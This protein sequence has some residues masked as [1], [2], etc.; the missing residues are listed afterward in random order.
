MGARVKVEALTTVQPIPGFG[1]VATLSERPYL[2][3]VYHTCLRC[4]RSLGANTELPHLRVGRKIA[5]DTRRGRLWVICSRC[6]QWNLTPLEERWE[7]LEEC[8]RLA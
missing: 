5:F 6:G 8:E 4:D 2:R 1:T 7:A 3:G